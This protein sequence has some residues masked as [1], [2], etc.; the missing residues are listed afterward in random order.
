MDITSGNAGVRLNKIGGNAKVDLQ[1]SDIMRAVDVK[2]DVDMKGKGS[3][4]ELENM[5]GQVTV[6]GSYS[7]TLQFKN[8][9]KPLHFESRNTDLRVEQLPGTITMDLGDF[10]GNEPDRP[11]PPGH[12]VATIFIWRI[13]RNRS[14]S[15]PSAAISS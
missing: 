8:L 6:N 9:A 11:D 5:A 1:R 15:R 7:G 10:T 4:V 13:S 3:D 2:G 12:A 14:N